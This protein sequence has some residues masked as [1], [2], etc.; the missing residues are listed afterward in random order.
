MTVVAISPGSTWPTKV[1]P[2]DRYERLIG[3]LRRTHPIVLVGGEKDRELCESLADGGGQRGTNPVISSAGETSLLQSAVLI[4]KAVIL[5]SGDSAPVQLASAMG[6]P[7]VV[8][9]GPTVPE[10]GFYPYSVPCRIIQ[11]QLSCRPCSSHGPVRCPLGHFKCMR[12]IGVD[13]VKEA[14]FDLMHETE[15]ARRGARNETP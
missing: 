12:D 13:A 2:V 5:I 9:Y 3:L 6:T 11:K 7:V 10:F 8:L 14:V 1:L 15:G 4:S